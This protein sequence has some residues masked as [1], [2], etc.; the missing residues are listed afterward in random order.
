M[1]FPSDSRLLLILVPSCFL[2]QL[3][4]LIFYDPA[5]S[6]TNNLLD[7][8]LPYLITSTFTFS[9]ACDRDESWFD[10]VAAE[11]LLAVPELIKYVICSTD[12]TCT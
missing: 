11:V 2:R 8:F 3:S 6:I 4:V 7:I 9:T 10:S 5:K 12:F 1:Q